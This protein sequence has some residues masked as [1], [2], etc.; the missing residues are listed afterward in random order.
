MIPPRVTKCLLINNITLLDS[1][2][3]QY[4]GRLWNMGIEDL[5]KLYKKLKGQA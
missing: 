4:S 3:K 1:T 5:Y 2:Y